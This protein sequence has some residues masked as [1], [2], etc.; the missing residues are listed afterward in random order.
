MDNT[1]RMDKNSQASENGDEEEDELATPMVISDVLRPPQ[2]RTKKSLSSMVTG[3]SQTPSSARTSQ[4]TPVKPLQSPSQT[5]LAVHIRSSPIIP[6][7]PI[8]AP[9]TRDSPAPHSRLSRIRGQRTS[10]TPVR[11]PTSGSL[12]NLG[13]KVESP[14]GSEPRKRG[15]PKGWKPGQPY[16][17]DPDSRYRKRE[18]REAESRTQERS[19]GPGKIQGQPQEAKRR[20]R[21]P[22]P[23]E[24]SVRE[25]YLQ[26][27]PDYIPYKCEWALSQDS[28]QQEP[29]LCPAELQNMDTLRRHVFLIHGD[30]DPLVCRFSHCKD[31]NPPLRF[32]TEKEF[33]SHMETKHFAIYLWHLGEG[34][35]NN[36]IWT[37]KNK[38]DE[39][40][41]YLFDKVG[42][43]VT[44]SVRDQRL[45]SDLQHKERKRKLKRLLNEQNE[46]A[47]SD[48]EW[49]KQM[50]GIS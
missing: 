36:G 35:Q 9:A 42:N 20:G 41:A 29:T 15:R 16:S 28:Q 3:S 39:L 47:I 45:E 23:L 48:E 38:S 2:H 19:P 13:T 25:Q 49:M 6:F 34:Y 14:S 24:P 4:Q 17:T 18:R 37:L 46:N 8:N 33:E 40:P 5:R 21:P 27:K 32:K 11:S 26:S 10:E 12:A 31:R 43:Q 50:L 30:G 44:P 7:T 22:R 1:M